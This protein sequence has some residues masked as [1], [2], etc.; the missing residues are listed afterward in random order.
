M[1][2]HGVQGRDITH[3]PPR[4]SAAKGTAPFDTLQIN[5]VGGDGNGTDEDASNFA[6]AA[7]RSYRVGAH[8][9][10]M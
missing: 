8:R 9:T 5:A 1:D 2:I 6:I 7:A 3:K 10:L 4:A